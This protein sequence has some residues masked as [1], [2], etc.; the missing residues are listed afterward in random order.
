MET[1]D[2]FTEMVERFERYVALRK[3]G[4]S[5][6]EARQKIWRVTRE[7]LAMTDEE[8]EERRASV[9]RRLRPSLVERVEKLEA[10]VAELERQMRERPFKG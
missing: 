7:H 10:R 5:S 9:L 3:E 6:D 4:A 1:P 2:D 8:W